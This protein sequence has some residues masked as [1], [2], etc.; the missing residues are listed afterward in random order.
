LE[1]SSEKNEEKTEKVKNATLTKSS[2]VSSPLQRKK[3]EKKEKKKKRR[4]RKKKKRKEELLPK[5]RLLMKLSKTKKTN[6][7]F[8]IN[9]RKK[10]MN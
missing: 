8:P 10:K 6:P 1:K 3:K 7:M 5:D 4:K 9:T 2:E